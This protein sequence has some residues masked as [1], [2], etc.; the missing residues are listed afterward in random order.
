MTEKRFFI[1]GLPHVIQFFKQE[2]GILRWEIRNEINMKTYGKGE[3]VWKD[4][5]L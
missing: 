1:E 2:G 5:K 4:M 3:L